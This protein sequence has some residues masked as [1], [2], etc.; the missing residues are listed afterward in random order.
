MS[1][2]P[3]RPPLP[4]HD[5]RTRHAY[6]TGIAFVPCFNSALFNSTQIHPLRRSVNLDTNHD[7]LSSR[8]H[9]GI[10]TL[11][12]TSFIPSISLHLRASRPCQSSTRSMTRRRCRHSTKWT[13]QVYA[14]G[15]EFVGDDDDGHYRQSSSHDDNSAVDYR[16]VDKATVARRRNNDGSRGS[17][18]SRR[19]S[20]S[21]RRRESLD[22]P[23]TRKSGVVVSEIVSSSTDED[24]I[25]DDIDDDDVNSNNNGTDSNF[26]N[27]SYESN[28]DDDDLPGNNNSNASNSNNNG[29]SMSNMDDSDNDMGF[30]LD[31][32]FIHSESLARHADERKTG[33]STISNIDHLADSEW[34]DAWALAVGPQ[35][36]I[37]L[38]NQYSRV[39]ILIE[40]N[41]SDFEAVEGCAD[42]YQ[43]ATIEEIAIE[44]A[45]AVH[46]VTGLPCI[47]EM[48]D[49]T[50]DAPESGS[51]IKK[52]LQQGYYTRNIA[53]EAEVMLDR[54]R[55]ISEENRLTR[56]KAVAVYYDGESQVVTHKTVTVVM[57]F[58]SA[59]KAIIATSGALDELYKELTRKFDLTM[60]SCD[61]GVLNKWG[62]LSSGGSG[63]GKRGKVMIGATLLRER[64]MR[65]SKVLG[66]GIIKVSSFLNHM[67]DTD[68]VE[69]CGKELAERL[70]NTAPN[71]VLTVESTGLIAGL[72]VARRLGIPLV[73]A[74]KS[75]PITISD[76]F[77]TTYRSATKGVTSELI[78]SCEYLESGDRVLIIDDFLAG[79]STAEGLFKLANMAHAKVV[80]VGVLIEKMSDGGRTF[81]SGYDVPVES[82][83]KVTAADG[84]VS[85]VEE[86]PWTPPNS[87]LNDDRIRRAASRK[88]QQYYSRTEGGDATAAS[89]PPYP[90]ATQRGGSSA[91]SSSVVDEQ[92][93][94]SIGGRFEQVV[95]D[96]HDD[97]DD[98]G[99]D[100]ADLLDDDDDDEGNGEDQVDIIRWEDDDMLDDIEDDLVR[101]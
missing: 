36:G 42:A 65:E 88:A 6:A 39:G 13:C 16:E 5:R 44:K 70:R 91:T 48:T 89:R 58:C 23:V 27:S 2:P 87:K 54:V 75:R 43:R 33:T 73:F 79:G 51:R 3:L 10:S 56:F 9:H 100:D 55:P 67:V 14:S 96:E 68:L 80:G 29:R 37:E 18:K 94:A 69:V 72:P 93:V 95:H 11:A 46:A 97:A 57:L 86:K 52:S 49:M 59:A 71:K 7:N 26:I 1:T 74:R 15:G 40:H 20:A 77:Q 28:D 85:V 24:A 61:D 17:S 101:K 34:S 8:R 92:V 4:T 38:K 31:G 76:S 62:N 90:P 81:L 12:T 53:A 47:A 41:F 21:S 50:I 83:A 25:N 98:M 78:V 64:I 32:Q 19:G 22:S 45:R 82:L 66:D 84:S 60:S 63:S 30:C 35:K 99:D